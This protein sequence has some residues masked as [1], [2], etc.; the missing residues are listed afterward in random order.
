MTTPPLS[1]ETQQK[2]IEAARQAFRH[3]YT[4]YSLF[5]VGASLL[6]VNEDGSE[7]LISGCNV[8]NA[9]FGLAICAERVALTKAVS[10]GHRHFKAIAIS[11]QKMQPCFP[12]GTCLQFIREF[13]A[14]IQVILEQAD[15]SAQVLPIAEMLPYT[16]TGEDL[17][18]S[19]EES[20]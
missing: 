11:A 14:D 6:A 13:G 20:D 2:L 3:S 5:P 18:R 1:N 17:R 10:E 8:E 7:S 19:D 9:S 12:C 15:G 16:F 4:P